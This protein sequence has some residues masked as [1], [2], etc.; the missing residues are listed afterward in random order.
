MK[1]IQGTMTEKEAIE[2]IN[3]ARISNSFTMGL[4]MEEYIQDIRKRY[5]QINNIVV[6]ANHIEI[7]K[8]LLQLKK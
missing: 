8:L 7:A 2:I 1:G 4:S 5:L 3:N 6:P